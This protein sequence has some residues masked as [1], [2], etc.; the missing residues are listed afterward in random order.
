MPLIEILVVSIQIY[1]AV[2]CVR[3]GQSGWLFIIILFPGIGS[4]IYFF[5]EYLPDMRS[6][7]IGAV[8]NL[9][10]TIISKINP[11]AELKRLRDQAEHNKCVANRV[12]LADA[13]VDSGLY[14]EAVDIYKG[15]RDGF[16]KDNKNILAGLCRAYLLQGNFEEAEKYL[17]NFQADTRDPL[18]REIRFQYARLLEEAGKDEEAL[19]EYAALL[20]ASSGEETRCRY[21]LLLKKL[22]RMEEAAS[23]FNQILK[24]A[25]VSPKFYRRNEKRW[26]SIA[27]K[28]SNESKRN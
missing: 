20:P 23:I 22:G 13:L 1:F 8:N 3:S 24:D 11:T 21:G 4:I 27:R 10:K 14:E 5:A 26:I 18:S 12:A 19:R 28:E 9:S 15:C 16:Y 25:A 2:H 17:V 7:R 6:G